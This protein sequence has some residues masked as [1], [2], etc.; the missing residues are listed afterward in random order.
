VSS[1]LIYLLHQVSL[2]IISLSKAL[3]PEAILGNTKYSLPF[4]LKY[5][6]VAHIAFQYCSFVCHLGTQSAVIFQGLLASFHTLFQV[7]AKFIF[8]TNQ[9]TGIPFV[10]AVWSA[11]LKLEK[12]I[13]NHSLDLNHV[14]VDQPQPNHVFKES[15]SFSSSVANQPLSSNH[16]SKNLFTNAGSAHKSHANQA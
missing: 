7:L 10:P 16:T 4:G 12:S 2:A 6:Q 9:L 14:Q 1:G 15:N 11:L 5:V 8:S 3:P 13:L